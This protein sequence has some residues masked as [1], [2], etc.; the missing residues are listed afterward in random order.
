M[1][2]LT[3]LLLQL[4]AILPGCIRS[5]TDIESQMQQIAVKLDENPAAA[6]EMLEELEGEKLTGR[7]LKARFA[8]LYSMALDKNCIDIASD[9]VINC[10][11]KYYSRFGSPGDKLLAHYYH[12]VTFLNAAD[13]DKAMD[14]FVKAGRYAGRCEDAVAVARL[15]TAKMLVYKYCLNLPSGS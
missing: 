11:V 9:S 1:R 8:L 14:C 12:G 5:T 10:A 7:R 13:I 2:R 15:Y 3:L 4:C 6:L